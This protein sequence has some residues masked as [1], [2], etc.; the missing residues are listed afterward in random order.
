M[1]GVCLSYCGQSSMRVRCQCS[2]MDEWG[3]ISSASGLYDMSLLALVVLLTGFTDIRHRALAL[4]VG[5][6]LA[7]TFALLSSIV[8]PC[9]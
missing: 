6:Y 8:E 3:L 2:L 9:V 7:S 1:H 4:V 5:R